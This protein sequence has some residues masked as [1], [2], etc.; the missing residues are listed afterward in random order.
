[1]NAPKVQ[2]PQQLI[3]NWNELHLNKDFKFDFAFKFGEK[4][5]KKI[6]IKKENQRKRFNSSW[7]FFYFLY[8][9]SDDKREI[10][11]PPL[12]DGLTLRRPMAIADRQQRSSER[13]VFSLCLFWQTSATMNDSSFTQNLNH[14]G[15]RLT[16]TVT[17]KRSKT[18]S[19]IARS[20]LPPR[21]RLRLDPTNNLYF[22]CTTPLCLAVGFVACLS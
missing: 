17:A 7:F 4:I 21:R 2:S 11:L 18:V 10:T 20:L 8:F 3:P 16:E 13:K 6:F 22:P 14:N 5:E 19:S 15:N 1:M 12:F 9:S